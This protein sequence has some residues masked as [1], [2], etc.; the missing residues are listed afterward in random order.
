MS[1]QAGTESGGKLIKI[2]AESIASADINIDYF[3]MANGI[4]V[5]EGQETILETSDLEA[6][7]A[8]AKTSVEEAIVGENVGQCLQS[9]VDTLQAAIIEAEALLRN[10]SAEQSQINEMVVKLNQSISL[11][12]NSIHVAPATFP[13]F[14]YQKVVIDPLGMNYN[15]TN[16]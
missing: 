15:P 16:Q 10:E 11:F 4:L 2:G 5:P 6:A 7:I 12:K 8:K 13:V 3:K 9:A 1:S 14:E